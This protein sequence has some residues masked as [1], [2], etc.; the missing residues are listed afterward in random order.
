MG[1]ASPAP[2]LDQLPSSDSAASSVLASDAWNG[3]DGRRG[4]PGLV[5][6]Q[7]WFLRE[8]TA[9]GVPTLCECWGF[10]C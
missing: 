5:F 2:G 10:L 7:G 9:V 3:A 1:A 6:G 8:G 4:V